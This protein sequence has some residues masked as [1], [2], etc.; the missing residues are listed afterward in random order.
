MRNICDRRPGREKSQFIKRSLTL[1]RKSICPQHGLAFRL[2]FHAFRD[3]S[4]FC[5]KLLEAQS[6]SS[7]GRWRRNTQAVQVLPQISGV[8]QRDLCQLVIMRDPFANNIRKNPDRI[9]KAAKQAWGN[10]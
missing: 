4:G 3:S 6:A 1:S 2:A 8:K 5:N 7:Q 10:D 9:K